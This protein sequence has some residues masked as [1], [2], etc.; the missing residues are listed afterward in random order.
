MYKEKNCN[1]S[2]QI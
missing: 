1:N 2:M